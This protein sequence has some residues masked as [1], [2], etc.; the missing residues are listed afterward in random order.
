MSGSHLPLIYQTLRSANRGRRTRRDQERSERLQSAEAPVLSRSAPLFAPPTKR[1][2]TPPIDLARTAQLR[3]DYDQAVSAMVPDR[4]K[5]RLKGVA[6][7][8]ASHILKTGIEVY[9]RHKFAPALRRLKERS[10]Q[11]AEA[12]ALATRARGG[13]RFLDAARPSPQFLDARRA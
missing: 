2:S 6:A 13:A 12:A 5:V 1:V 11:L 9:R 3:R 10:R 8:P 4:A 7:L